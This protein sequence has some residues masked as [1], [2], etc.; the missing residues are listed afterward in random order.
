MKLL[1]DV[2]NRQ[3]R[4]TDKHFVYLE[5][6]HPEMVGQIRKIEETLLAPDCIVRSQIDSEVELFYKYYPNTPVTE[7]YLCV[8][9][10]MLTDNQFMITS[11]SRWTH[12]RGLSEI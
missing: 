7:K 5:T 6:D 9:V 1:P 10:K 12:Q 11:W 2:F 3:I 8:V 4:L